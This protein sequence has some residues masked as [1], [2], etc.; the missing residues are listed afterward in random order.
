M[1]YAIVGDIHS[2][3]KD[4]EA[5]LKQVAEIAPDAKL[6]GTGDLFECTISKR[7]ITDF[8]YEKMEDVMQL[9]EGFRDLLT[10]PSIRGN[11][12]ERIVFITKTDDPLRAEL[13]KLPE[14]MQIGEAFVIHGHQ[15]HYGDNPWQKLSPDWKLVFFGHTHRSEIFRNGQPECIRFGEEYEI[16]RERTIVNVGSVIENR[17]W[18]L[19]DED[20]AV[21]RFMKA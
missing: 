6:V 14:T 12:E 16:G 8:K 1:R 18:V 10:F 3:T 13:E 20:N 17:E 2:S 5:V 4:L 9:P 19:Y 21:I 11:Q 7:N 15:W